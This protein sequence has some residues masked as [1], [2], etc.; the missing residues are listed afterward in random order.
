MKKLVC[1]GDSITAREQSNDGTNRLTPRLRSGLVGWEVINAGVSGDN[2]RD[3]LLRVEEDVLAH[4]P[5]LVTILLGANDAATHKMIEL[6]EYSDNLLH[7]IKKITPQKA[8]LITPSPV[9]E[10]RPRNRTNASLQG[11]ANVVKHIANSMGS[12]FVDLFSKMIKQPDYI[13]MLSDGLHF[14]E[15]GYIFLSQLLLNK[16]KDIQT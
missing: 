3:A 13:E 9:D 12:Q 14:T 16:I 10:Q 6:E 7:I 11:Y 2:T 15:P 8:I 4:S 1:F 5:N